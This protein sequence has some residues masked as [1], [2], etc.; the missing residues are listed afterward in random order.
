MNEALKWLDGETRLCPPRRSGKTETGT[1]APDDRAQASNIIEV[2]IAMNEDASPAPP[3]NIHSANN[4]IKAG[5]RLYVPTFPWG[6]SHALYWRKQIVLRF[7][8][9]PG[10]KIRKADVADLVRGHEVVEVRARFF[11]RRGAIPVMQPVDIDIV[12]LKA[13]QRRLA[14]LHQGLAT[15]AAAV[16]IALVF[17][18]PNRFVQISWDLS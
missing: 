8:D 11:D 4:P 1:K 16:R 10:R 7:R 9:L 5:Y 13:A 18:P 2:W 17:D 3:N 14:L 12:G 15:R 6:F